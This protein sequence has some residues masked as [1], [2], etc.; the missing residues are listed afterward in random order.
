[1]ENNTLP[2]FIFN[3]KNSKDLGIVVKEMPPISKSEKNI[4]KIE[5]SGRTGALYIDNN[6][7]LQKQY[8]ITCILM[9]D[10]KLRE[11]NSVYDGVGRLELS[12]EPGI[13]YNAMIKNQIDFEKYLTY[14]KTFVLQFDVYP[15]GFSL[16]EKKLELLENTEFEVGGTAEVYPIIEIIGQGAFSL[17]NCQVEVFE[18]GIKID[19]ELMNCTIDNLN[20][21]DKVNLEK[22]PK[23]IPGKN[24]LTI[25]GEI[26]KIIINYHEGWL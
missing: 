3:G 12:A 1:M 6:T 14:L 18:S 2:F 17:N 10:S 25:S 8:S 21:N 5:V 19:C 22:F 4:E 16:E 9:D 7:Y 24:N 15:I 11:I 26:E 20:K 23:L 13:V